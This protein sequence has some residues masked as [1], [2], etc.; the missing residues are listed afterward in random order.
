MPAERIAISDLRNEYLLCRALGHAW[1]EIPNAE[2]SPEL[3][4]TSSAALAVRCVR[5]TTERHDYLDKQFDVSSRQYKYP[6]MYM[7]IVGEGKRPNVRGELLSRS[8]LLHRYAE[9][10][11][12]ARKR[13]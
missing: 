8:L 2:F 11:N 7:G 9:R 1:E 6:P 13:R 3:W 12:G 10:A 5:C 4:R